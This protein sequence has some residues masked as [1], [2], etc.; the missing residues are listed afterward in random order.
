MLYWT[1]KRQAAL[2]FGAPAEVLEPLLERIDSP[3]RLADVGEWLIV[4]TLD[5]LVAK[6]RAEVEA[7]HT[8]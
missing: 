1:L 2:R 5:Q 7:N 6:L 3:T 4:D 8:H